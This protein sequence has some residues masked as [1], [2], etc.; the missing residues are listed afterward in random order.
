MRMTS[1]V[2]CLLLGSA[3]LAGV[4]LGC[5]ESP[6]SVDPKTL[7]TSPKSG[8]QLWADNC[9]RCH[10][11]RSPTSYSDAEWD[12]VLHHMRLQAHLTG[13]EQRAIAA[14]LKSA[15]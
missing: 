6:D 13:A 14:Y 4:S 7:R 3:L 2:A 5:A 8:V 12:L 1:R 9:A 10:D 11:S 15:N